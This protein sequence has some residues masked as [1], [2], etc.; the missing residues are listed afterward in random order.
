M[1]FGVRGTKAAPFPSSLAGGRAQVQ[2]GRQDNF[3]NPPPPAKSL[4][5]LTYFFNLQIFFFFVP[6][7]KALAFDGYE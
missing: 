5:M 1:A 6:A 4:K 7:S 2:S 3:L